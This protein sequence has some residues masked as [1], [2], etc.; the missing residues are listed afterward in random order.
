MKN[1]RFVFNTFDIFF[2]FLV[3]IKPQVE[4]DISSFSLMLE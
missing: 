3:D 2:S 1:W 4:V